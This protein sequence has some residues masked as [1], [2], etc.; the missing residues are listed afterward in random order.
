MPLCRQ[1]LEI[2]RA[3]LGEAHPDSFGSLLSLALLHRRWG[4]PRP[5]CLYSSRA[6]EITRA[7]LGED[8]P[9]YAQA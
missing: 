2:R 6:A 8:H 1:A 3:T 4:P 7:A 9:T 5:P